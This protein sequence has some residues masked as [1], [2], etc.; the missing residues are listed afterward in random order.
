MASTKVVSVFIKGMNQ[1]LAVSKNDNEHIFYGLDFD[2]AAEDGQDLGIPHNTKGNS[3]SFVIPDLPP[4]YTIELNGNTGSPIIDIAG[5]GPLVLAIT[6]E[7]T[8]K[9]IYDEIVAAYA[10]QIAAGQYGVFY[11]NNQ[12]YIIGYTVDP[13]VLAGPAS[14]GIFATQIVTAQA[15]LSIIGSCLLDEELILLTT[16]KTNTTT[17]PSGTAGQIWRVSFNDANNT[18]NNLT[19]NSLTPQFH[20][21]KNDILNFSLAWEVYREMVG[22]VESSTSGS[23]YWTDDNNSPRAI[24]IYNAQAGAIP[25]GLLDWKPEVNMSTPIITGLLNGGNLKV[26]SYQ[27]A[28]LEYSNDGAITSFSPASTL[29]PITDEPFGTTEWYRFDGAE[30]GTNGGKS[31]RFKVPLIDRRYDYIRL[32]VIVYELQNSPKLYTFADQVI[33]DDSMEFLY[34]GNEFHVELSINDFLNPQISFDKA[35]TIAQKKNRLYV[36]NTTTN[37]F[38]FEW[39]ARAYRFNSTPECNLYKRSSATATTYTPADLVGPTG[40]LFTLPDTADAVNAYNDES[41]QIFGLDPAGDYTADWLAN[42]QFKYQDDGVTLGGSGINISYEFFVKTYTGDQDVTTIPTVSPFIN[43]TT[44]NAGGSTQSIY[45][46]VIASL[47]PITEGWDSIKNPFYSMTFPSYSRGEIYRFGIVFYNLKGQQSFVKWIGDIRIPE[48]WENSNFDLSNLNGNAQE[49]RAIGLTFTVDTSNLPSEVTGFR[50]VR[51]ARGDGD[52]TR[53]GIGLTSGLCRYKVKYATDPSVPEPVGTD[54]WLL[55]MKT[56]SNGVI[57]QTES[58][59]EINYNFATTVDPGINLIGGSLSLGVIKFPDFDFGKYQINQA[60]HIKK[61]ARY[62][63]TNTTIEGDQNPAGVPVGNM[64]WSWDYNL[65]VTFGQA[66]LH[67]LN[68]IQN[69][70]SAI[71][72]INVQ[73]GVGIDGQVLQSFS[74]NMGGDDYNHVTTFGFYNGAGP[75]YEDNE[76][77]GLGTKMLFV[78]YADSMN[79]ALNNQYS[80]V[81]LCR[82]NQGQYGGP[83][84]SAR[85]NNIYQACSDFVPKELYNAS[86]QDITVFGGDVYVSYYVTPYVFFHWGEDYGVSEAT[87]SGLA[88]NYFPLA[89]TQLALAIAFPTEC[90]INTDLRYGTYFNKNQVNQFEAGAPD[91]SIN[92]SPVFAKFLRDD[93]FFNDAMAQQNNIVPYIPAPLLLTEDET[94]R[95]RIWASNFKIDR[96]I[97]N[98]WRQFPFGQ[99]IDLEG[100]YGGITKVVNLNEQIIGVQER[101]IAGVS[102]EELTTVPNASG[103]TFQAGTGALLSRYDYKTKESGAYHQHAVFTSPSSLY[104]Y[105][106]RLQKLFRIG[107]GLEPLTD[108]QGLSAFFRD[109]ITGDV[110]TNDTVLLNKGIHGSFDTKYNKAY[111]TFEK[112]ESFVFTTSSIDAEGNGYYTGYNSSIFSL[113]TAGQTININNTAYYIISLTENQ[114]VIDGLVPGASG[115]R[116]VKLSFTVAYNEFLGGFEDFYSF[117]PTLY[118]PTGKRFLSAN[119]YDVNNSAYVHNVGD[120][121]EFYNQEPSIS[122]LRYIVNYPDKG[123]IP[124]FRLDTV[125]FWSQVLDNNG[126]NITLESL[127]GMLITNDY[128]STVN[129]LNPLTIQN[130]EMVKERTWRINLIRDNN[131]LTRDPLPHIR[132]KYS[133]ITAYFNNGNNRS[134][135]L[136]DITSTITLSAY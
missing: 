59:L 19:G 46:P 131:D 31:I 22:R 93:F 76:V 33:T 25:P 80:I 92:A 37:R 136:H 101:G 124:T 121:G 54:S 109:N 11:N 111:F 63:I 14:D 100:M 89:S 2:L 115:T 108:M 1:D 87:P 75:W 126:Q 72:N 51:V 83:W 47:D 90:S 96:E 117:T 7:T 73:T 20:L 97:I 112:T 120:Y 29:L 119:P 40:G 127:S 41:G 85:Y 55:A 104:Y 64:Y 79:Y 4:V 65:G 27:F 78:D 77:C 128:Q 123:K 125:Q 88:G 134:L 28:Y 116:T 62:D 52:K 12:V 133:M 16:S 24:N 81:S 84:R 99:K 107:N 42:Y 61:I 94:N 9:D 102:S 26:G 129:S 38:D 68:T 69:R 118:M 130:S 58:T 18:V 45:N 110:R 17:T 98:S 86:S 82:F 114:L 50:I 56:D 91:A 10:V 23:V 66:F 15:D 132:D 36:G 49:V 71:N 34:T 30:A 8:I 6:A 95:T 13:A 122:T 39:D 43:V 103:G 105:D 60:S 35:K 70:S 21:V 113:Y 67:K 3:L 32:A 48:P 106:I 74:G 5:V 57:T 135:R 53:L 44:S